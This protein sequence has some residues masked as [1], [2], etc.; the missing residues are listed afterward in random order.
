M[1]IRQVKKLHP[2]MMRHP[3][4]IIRITSMDKVTNKE[5]LERT[6]LPSMDQKESS[7]DWTPPEDVIRQTTKAGSL[8]PTFSHK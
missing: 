1:Y 5:T 7:L 4:S 2:F 3:R 6:G 8:L